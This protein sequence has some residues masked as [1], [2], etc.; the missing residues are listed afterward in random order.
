MCFDVVKRTENLNL[1]NIS[2][3]VD[4]QN[5]AR[6]KEVVGQGFS[7]LRTASQARLF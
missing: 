1:T 5:Q 2:R 6:Q 7:N 3:S 4:G